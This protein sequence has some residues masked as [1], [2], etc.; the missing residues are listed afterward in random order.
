MHELEPLIVVTRRVSRMDS[1]IVDHSVRT[2]VNIVDGEQVMSTYNA[3]RE[4]KICG[5]MLS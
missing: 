1:G 5:S 2:S 3:V 4:H